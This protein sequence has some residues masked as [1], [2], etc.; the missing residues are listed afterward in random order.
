MVIDLYR[1]KAAGMS[2]AEA[3][4]EVTTTYV[5]SVKSLER[6]IRLADAE[7][8]K[9]LAANNRLGKQNNLR[10]TQDI[11]D[12]VDEAI[13][14]QPWMTERELAENLEERGVV[15][16]H[17][18]AGR[19]RKKLGWYSVVTRK[20]TLLSNSHKTALPPY[21]SWPENTRRTGP[22]GRC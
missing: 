4:A 9:A 8:S 12:I 5:A 20:V 6:F 7:G 10:L 15:V 2:T 3:K 22:L 16:D 17:S 11:I 19:W 1:M 13:A 21:L 14:A 18:T